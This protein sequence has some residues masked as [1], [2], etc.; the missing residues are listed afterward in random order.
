MSSVVTQGTQLAYSSFLSFQEESAAVPG[1]QRLQDRT[2]LEYKPGHS[3]KPDLIAPWL[4]GVRSTSIYRRVV[5]HLSP[6]AGAVCTQPFALS[7]ILTLKCAWW[8]FGKQGK[9]Q[10]LCRLLLALPA[11]RMP[12]CGCAF[13]R[14]A[15]QATV[16]RG[17]WTICLHCRMWRPSPFCRRQATSVSNCRDT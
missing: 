9:L 13:E 5:G 2:L 8:H 17:S 15:C 10:P 12:C 3:A 4:T 16:W 6:A 14:W 1:L 7:Q 11:L